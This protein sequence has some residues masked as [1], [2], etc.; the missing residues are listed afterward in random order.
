MGAQYESIQVGGSLPR[1]VVIVNVSE[2]SRRRA[3]YVWTGM[4]FFMTALVASVLLLSNSSRPN[5]LA[6]KGG[7]YTHQMLAQQLAETKD[8]GAKCLEKEGLDHDQIKKFGEGTLCLGQKIQQNMGLG[9]TEEMIR[10][11]LEAPMNHK[12]LM[13]CLHGVDDKIAKA[14]HTCLANLPPPQARSPVVQFW[15]RN[16]VV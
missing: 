2:P 7:V 15:K 3:Q 6:A 14:V 12:D 1:E 13:T 8:G 9:D 5:V 11:Y 10:D 16:T 4:A